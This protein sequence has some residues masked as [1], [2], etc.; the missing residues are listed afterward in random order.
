MQ[1]HRLAIRPVM[2]LVRN[3]SLL[4]VLLTLC[5]T[6]SV[7]AETIV[8]GSF[9]TGLTSWSTTGDASAAVLG[10]SHATDGSSVA[11]IGLGGGFSSGA[12][13]LFQNFNLV[14]ASLFNYAFQA[15]RSE[16]TSLSDDVALSFTVR[17]DGII[18]STALP[19]FD[20]S[21]NGSAGGTSLL[22]DYAGSLFLSAG[23]HQLVFE[24]TRGGSGFLRGPFFVLDGVSVSAA[25]E[26][27]ETPLPAA[28]P[29]FAAGLGVLGFVVR[30]KRKTTA[31]A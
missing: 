18:L 29:L 20:S 6:P 30:R 10:S 1:R 8:N 5:F 21:S 23:A 24:F 26:V 31:V 25:S 16:S 17:I 15:G 28:L 22:S 12:G 2:A 9:E 19:A 27:G 3:C 14:N 11:A 13:T 7:R 4:S